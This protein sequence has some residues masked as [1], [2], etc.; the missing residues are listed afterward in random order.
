MCATNNGCSLLN[1][2]IVHCDYPPTASTN[3]FST[4]TYRNGTLYVPKG[5]YDIYG[6][7]DA[8]REFANIVEEGG[9][10]GNIEGDVNG[11]GKVDVSDV[12]RIIDIILGL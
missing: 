10:G 3:T 4:E 1:K 11:D 7:K 6:R 9:T 5:K 12:N 8:W 2:V